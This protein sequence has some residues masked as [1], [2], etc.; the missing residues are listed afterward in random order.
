[1]ENSMKIPQ[2]LKLSYDPTILLLAIYPDKTNSKR[3]VD[4][5]VHSSTIYNRQDIE[6]T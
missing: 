3:Y 5:Y 1:M 6:T 2:K 4:L